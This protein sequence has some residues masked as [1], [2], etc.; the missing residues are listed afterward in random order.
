MKLESSHDI[1]DETLTEFY[2]RAN[3]CLLLDL[4]I[5]YMIKN[6]FQRFSDTI[7]DFT[8]D[9]TQK[10]DFKEPFLSNNISESDFLSGLR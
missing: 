2:G 5:V 3:N 7:K 6:K 10:P 8:S 9:L 1:E 4:Q